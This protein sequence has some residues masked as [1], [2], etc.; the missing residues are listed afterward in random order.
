MPPRLSTST[1]RCF[2]DYFRMFLV[3]CIDGVQRRACDRVSSALAETSLTISCCAKSFLFF[4]FAKTFLAFPSLVPA[5]STYFILFKVC[6]IS[7]GGFN[8]FLSLYNSFFSI[9]FLKKILFVYF[10]YG[11]VVLRK[12]AH[13]TDWKYVPSIDGISRN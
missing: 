13:G 6:K 1:T 7:C 11:F 3:I 8:S 4:M 5:P 9:F 2:F 12:I 10:V